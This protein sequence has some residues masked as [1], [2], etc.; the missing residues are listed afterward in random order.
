M[1]GW[2]HQLHGHDLEQTPGGGKGQRSLACCSPWGCQ[3]SDPTQQLNN[4]NKPIIK[5]LTQICLQYGRPG[6][7]PWV[8]KIPWR[9]ERQPTPVF[10]P[11]EFHGLY[12][13]WGRKESDTNE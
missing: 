5:T 2:H 3:E 8:G 1:V 12:S 13:P 6:F 10:W 11:G 4:S 9:R 7:D